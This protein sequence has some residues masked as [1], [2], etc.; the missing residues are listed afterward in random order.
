MNKL[1]YHSEVR[2]NLKHLC[3]YLLVFTEN[4]SSYVCSE[5]NSVEFCKESI[6][7]LRITVDIAQCYLRLIY[8]LYL[9]FKAH[10]FQT[11]TEMALFIFLKSAILTEIPNFKTEM[12]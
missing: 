7:D 10:S 5:I 12:L 2:R 9:I 6:G 3:T 1:S 4:G 11:E 8:I